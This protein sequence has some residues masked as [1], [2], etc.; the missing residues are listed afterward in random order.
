MAEQP[1][2][3][4]PPALA[5]IVQPPRPVFL[6]KIGRKSDWGSDETPPEE[7]ATDVVEL[8][9]NR[10]AHPFSVYLVGSNQDLHRVIIGMNGGRDSLSSESYFVALH[11]HELEAVGIRIDHTPVLPV[12]CSPTP[13]TTT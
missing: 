7:R 3:P 4:Q 9:F 11:R 10:K 12:V 13:C 8:V 6:R 5:D 1:Q 2:P